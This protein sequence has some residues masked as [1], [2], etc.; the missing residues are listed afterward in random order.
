MRI[1]GREIT[2]ASVLGFGRT[3]RAVMEFLLAREIEPFVSETKFLAESD[4][5]LLASSGVSYEEGGHT[6]K[7]LTGSDLIVLSPGVSPCHPLLAE[8]GRRGILV[9]SEIDLASQVCQA[10]P[11]IAVT[12][13]NG[14]STTVLIIAAL[15]RQTG[16]TAVVAGN[17]GIPFISVVEKANACDAIVLEVSSFQLEQSLF[18]HPCVAVLLNI[19][20]DHLERHKTVALYKAAKG[21]I[22]Q[23]QTREE[24]AILRSDLISTYPEIKGRKVLFDRVELPPSSFVEKLPPHN[25]ANLQAAI[26]ACAAFSPDFDPDS[27]RF[28]ELEGA[29]TLP[30]RLQKE[31]KVDGIRV[32]NDSKSTNA[33]STIAALRSI[34]GPLVLLLGGRHKQAGYDLLAEAISQR[35]VRAVIVYGDA[36]PFLSEVLQGVEGVPVISSPDLDQAIRVALQSACTGDTLLFSPACSSYDQFRDYIERGETFSRLIRAYER[37]GVS[38]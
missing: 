29:F 21:R 20:P 34:E 15:L 17:I 26:A 11:I 36:A 23:H 37:R 33:D 2:R 35:S 1:A 19:T 27:I 6:A 31:G 30:Y 38:S 7:I 3:G 4:R 8:A 32:I 25:R 28:D 14:K 9:L 5:A 18:F 24:V 13:T 12:G 22:F 10:V 16:R